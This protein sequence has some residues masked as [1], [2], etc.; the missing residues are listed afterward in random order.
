ML[1]EGENEILWEN[2]TMNRQRTNDSSQNEQTFNSFSIKVRWKFNSLYV[3]LKWFHLWIFPQFLT[4]LDITLTFRYRLTDLNSTSNLLEILDY[5][6]LF[7]VSGLYLFT[8]SYELAT[9]LRDAVV[10]DRML[11]F[12]AE[13]FE[14]CGNYEIH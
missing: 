14:W 13:K 5:R 7:Y 8:L 4:L 9:R 10:N 1:L 3:R 2:Y 6:N 11:E 12:E